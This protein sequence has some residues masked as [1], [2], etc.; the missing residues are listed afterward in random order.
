MTFSAV[1]VATKI[2]ATGHVNLPQADRARAK[3]LKQAAAARAAGKRNGESFWV[4]NA[5]VTYT[6]SVGVGSPATDCKRLT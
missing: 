6:A 1:F 5:A 4:T 2:N 3:A